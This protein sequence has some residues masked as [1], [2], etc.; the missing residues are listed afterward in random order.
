MKWKQITVF[1]AELIYLLFFSI[2]NFSV[3]FPGEPMSWQFILGMAIFSFLNFGFL[4]LCI[5]HGFLTKRNTIVLLGIAIVLLSLYFLEG[6]KQVFRIKPGGSIYSMERI[7]SLLLC[8]EEIFFR[9]IC[10]ITALKSTTK[11]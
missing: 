6:T 10:L 4:L 1:V 3:I 11:T 9:I 5:H 7:K 8:T 2:G